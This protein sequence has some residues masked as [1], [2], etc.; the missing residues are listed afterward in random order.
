MGTRSGDL[1]P[2]VPLT[3]TASSA[4]RSTTIDRALNRESGLKGSPGTTTF[5]EVL[6]L[7]VRGD[8]PR[9]RCVRRLRL[10]DPQVRRRLLRRARQRRRGRL[11]RRRRRARPE[12]RARQS[13]RP[14]AARHR[15][16]PG[17]QRPNRSRA[18]RAISTDGSRVAR[19]WWCRPT[20]SGRR[21]RAQAPAVIRGR[22]VTTKGGEGAVGRRRRAPRR[23]CSRTFTSTQCTPSGAT[24][25]GL[26]SRSDTSGTSTTSWPTP[27]RIAS[28]ASTST[29]A[30]PR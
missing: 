7:R 13:G 6:A 2:A 20:R 11:H 19:Y 4:G 8:E 24:S 5:R 30:L 15:G 27:T 21:S 29:P 25:S 12:L 3:C 28:S 18:P 16:R 10:P 22:D 9:P 1:D 23:A 26:R 17:P 14:G